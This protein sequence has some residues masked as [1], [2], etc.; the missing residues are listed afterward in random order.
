MN[1]ACPHCGLV[2]ER[3]PGYFLGAMYVSYGI[4]IVVLGLLM[5][6]GHLLFPDVDLGAMVLIA[7][8][9]YLPFVP[10]AFRYSRVVWMHFDRWA[11]PE[12]E[13]GRTPPV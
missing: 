8:A 9:V 2:F 4:S 7:A 13:P 1:K 11:W 5:L 10:M 6:V 12:Q 3:E